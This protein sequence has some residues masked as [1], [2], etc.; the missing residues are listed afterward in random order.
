M[1]REGDIKVN[2]ID[3]KKI[4]KKE[5]DTESSLILEFLKFFEC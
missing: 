3:G 5:I 1:F 2:E 4:M